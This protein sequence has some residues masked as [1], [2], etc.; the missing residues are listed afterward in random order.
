MV[1]GGRSMRLSKS[2][3]FKGFLVSYILILLLPI[4]VAGLVYNKAIVIMQNNAIKFSSSHLN[5]MKS[6][7][8]KEL[9]YV[10]KYILE[11]SIKPELRRINNLSSPLPGSSEM[12][13]FY[14]FYRLY[15]NMNFNNIRDANRLFLLLNNNQTVFS[16]N[17]V[18]FSFEDFYQ[19][20][21][22]YEQLDY[23]QWHDIYFNKIYYREYF[24][25]QK[26]K[27]NGIEGNYITSLYTLPIIRDFGKES[28]IEG[29]IAYLFDADELRGMLQST[30]AETGGWAYIV[31]ANNQILVSTDVTGNQEMAHIGKEDE[32][33][34]IQ[35]MNGEEMMAVYTRLP[36]VSWT[37]VSI[38]PLNS[39]RASFKDFRLISIGIIIITFLV[40]MMGSL[41]L[42][43]R[44]TKPIHTLMNLLSTVFSEKSFK[45]KNE[46]V[47]IQD[48]IKTIITDNNKMKDS[49]SQQH[50]Y[51]TIL[52][53]EKLL[54][55]ELENT[56]DF[57][58]SL[59]HMGVDLQ[60][61]YYI[62]ILIRIHSLDTLVTDDILFEQDLFRVALDQALTSASAKKGYT[63]ILNQ[64]ELALLL[65]FKEKENYD[66]H[67]KKIM[68]AVSSAFS[69]HFTIKPI[70]AIGNLKENLVDIHF[71]LKEARYAADSIVYNSTGA[72]VVW[73][74]EI[75]H[76]NNEY[77][78]TNEIE[79]RVVNMTRQGNWQDLKSLLNTIYIHTLGNQKMPNHMKW[80]LIN[81]LYATIVKLSMDLQMDISLKPVAT[82]IDVGNLEQYFKELKIEYKQICCNLSKNKKSH[83][84]QLKESIIEYMEQN[85]TDSNLSVAH[86]S[87]RFNLSE[88]YFSQFFK[89][90]MNITYSQYLEVLRIDHACSLLLNTDMTI[91]EIAHQSGYNNPNTFRRAFGRVKGVSPTNYVKANL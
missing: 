65:S 72:T 85:F 35:E 79:Q 62:I 82:V 12:Y 27:V 61:P 31:D 67:I 5:H 56:N 36:Y 83:N 88:G 60:G 17:Y 77:Y 86:L 10:D 37:Y 9:L 18:S 2:R 43:Y 90:Q 57:K 52:Y 20:Y 22:G 64:N 68:S 45:E 53:F 46:L 34:M 25:E 70:F 73:Y 84:E 42:S 13:W 4:F 48:E 87:E 47:W 71:S 50:Q 78:Y 11:L 81:D 24:P 14:D 33:Y 7:M 1:L 54:R 55:G 76:K 49:L 19:D 16:Q 8:E 21:F 75:G 28:R 38:F 3:S 58:I 39:I 51:L 23:E 66:N 91:H 6:L 32:G 26:M 69:I 74:K 30:I 59:R 15:N 44:N 41:F 80:V 29:V 40:G 89:E 63:H